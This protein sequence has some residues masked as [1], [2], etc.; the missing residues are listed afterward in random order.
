MTFAL[1]V[2][3]RTAL[4]VGVIVPLSMTIAGYCCNSCW[5]ASA[6]VEAFDWSSW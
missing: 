4:Q 5:A 1:V 6:A 3:G 2:T